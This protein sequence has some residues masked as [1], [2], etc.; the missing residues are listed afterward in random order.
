MTEEKV[1]PTKSEKEANISS[2]EDPRVI[3]PHRGSYESEGSQRVGKADSGTEER[4]PKCNA[5]I[6]N[7][8]IRSGDC[9]RWVVMR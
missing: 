2:A 4:C 6:T 1:L 5:K 7:L 8:R 9:C 3:G